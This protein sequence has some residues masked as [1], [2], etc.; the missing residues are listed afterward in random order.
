MHTNKTAIIGIGRW[1]T[2]VL[3]KLIKISDVK[4]AVYNK[5]KLPTAQN[6]YPNTHFVNKIDLVLSDPEVNDV[7]ITTPISTHYE[8]AKR[9]LSAGKNTFVEKPLSLRVSEVDELYEIAHSN[10]CRLTSGYLHLHDTSVQKLYEETA[11]ES[12]IKLAMVWKKWGTFE[13][14]IANNILVHDLAVTFKLLGTYQSHRIIINTA[15]YFEIDIKCRRGAANISIDRKSKKREKKLFLQA[16]E[17]TYDASDG[18]LTKNGV[19]INTKAGDLLERELQNFLDG[20]EISDTHDVDKTIA[21]LLEQL[22]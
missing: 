20:S 3:S 22:S 12:D 10:N 9:C 16:G 15:D 14:P 11:Q 7:F 5:D 17:T 13:E 18:A 19:L 2:L 8:M 6:D 21:F 1:G 4:F